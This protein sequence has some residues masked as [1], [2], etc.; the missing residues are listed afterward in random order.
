MDARSRML[1][2]WSMTE[3]RTTSPLRCGPLRLLLLLLRLRANRRKPDYSG[4][5]DDFAVGIEARPMARTVPGLLCIVPVDDTVQVSAYC[6][7]L[8]DVAALVAID[9][10]LAS[11]AADYRSFARLDDSDIADI[12][13]RE[14]IPVLLGDVEILLDVFRCRAKRDTRWVVEPRPLVLSTLHK[15]VENYAGDGSVSH[16]VA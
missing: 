3:R 10:D 4:T 14:V 8:M 5:V 6:R 13:R 16:S 1:F 11:T 7:V 12:T 15:L 2:L 9:G